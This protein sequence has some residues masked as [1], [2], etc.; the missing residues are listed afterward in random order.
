MTGGEH[1]WRRTGV[2]LTEGK[3]HLLDG[4]AYIGAN[5]TQ[6]W[7]VEGQLHR[8]DGP[9]IIRANGSR[10]WCVNG[11]DFTPQVEGWMTEQG[12]PPFEMWTHRE[13]I[14]FRLMFS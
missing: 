13:K 14:L 3:L 12:I 10:V 6:E 1:Q 5:G 9:A 11:A 2:G 8:L 7:R 4:P